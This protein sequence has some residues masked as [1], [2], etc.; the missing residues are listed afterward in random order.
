MTACH[1]LILDLTSPV[2]RA[3]LVDGVG[4][5]VPPGGL[6]LPWR[7]ALRLEGDEILT[8]AGDEVAD[9]RSDGRSLVFDRLDLD[10][11]RIGDEQLQFDLAGGFWHTLCRRLEE[12]G[13]LEDGGHAAG[14]VITPH[15]YTP[16]LLRNFRA[17]CASEPRMMV[18]GFV[19]EALALALGFVRSEHFDR[20]VVEDGSSAHT[21]FCLVT[22]VGSEQVEVTYFNY[23]EEAAPRRRRRIE[24]RDFFRATSGDL[25]ARLR[26]RQW[27]QELTGLFSELA[28]IAD[29]ELPDVVRSDIERALA[30][31]GCTP[32]RYG[33]ADLQRL[34]AGG[35]SVLANSALGRGDESCEYEV[36][37]A[38]GIGVQVSR[39][40]ICPVLPPET[41]ARLHDFPHTARK[42]FRL[43]AGPSERLE[44]RLCC[45]FTGRAD[46]ALTL[47]S[48]AL[49]P[50]DLGALRPSSPAD[51]VVT[52]SLDTPGGGDF[53]VSTFPEGVE[54]GRASFTLPGLIV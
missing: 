5:E 45:G 11:Q 17:A 47:G 37:A 39:E 19:D 28:L 30:G 43:R 4:G 9:T 34:K 27:P 2:A 48:V 18:A 36:E 35:V 14:Y 8:L 52:V 15:S 7:V 50:G 20:A 40:E 12:H 44:L 53:S 26:S 25:G 21:S 31:A 32:S 22:A 3:V 16:T 51:L 10:L 1:L 54:I 13:M 29:R 46:E 49:N 23:C 33:V 41:L 6:R 38:V 42:A 24:I